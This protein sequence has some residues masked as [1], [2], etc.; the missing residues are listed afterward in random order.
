M[1]TYIILRIISMKYKYWKKDHGGDLSS[2]PT[3]L[4]ATVF[5]PKSFV[6]KPKKNRNIEEKVHKENGRFLF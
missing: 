3:R 5:W 2:H 1:N 4:T 6:R